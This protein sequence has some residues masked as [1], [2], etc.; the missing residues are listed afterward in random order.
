[1]KL[2]VE[3]LLD[4][5]SR[6]EQI[7]PDYEIYIEYPERYGLLRIDDVEIDVTKI[8]D[9]CISDYND[10]IPACTIGANFDKKRLYIFHHY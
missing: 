3:Q 1:M 6:V 7:T 8:Y 4:F 5:I 9:E 2:T 10:M